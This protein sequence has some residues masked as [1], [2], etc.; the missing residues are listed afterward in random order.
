LID[1]VP[2]GRAVA[3]YPMSDLTLWP[4]NVSGECAQLGYVYAFAHGKP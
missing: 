1:E 3:D 2:P 4:D